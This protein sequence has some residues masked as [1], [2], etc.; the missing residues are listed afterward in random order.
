MTTRPNTQ[1]GYTCPKCSAVIHANNGGFQRHV[2]TCGV[3]WREYFWAKVDKNA[4]NGCWVWTASRKEKGYGQFLL[5]RK[6]HRAHRL[7]WKLL[8]GDPG[9][10]EVAHTCDNRLCVNPDHLF[11]ATHAENMADCKAKGRH[12]FGERGRAK[13]KEADVLEIRRLKGKETAVQLSAK[14]GVLPAHI[15]RIWCRA[16]WRHI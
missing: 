3:D 1:E 16:F 10:K 15:S 12:A 11:L 5:K 13:L 7:A 2:K 9:D 6:M 14:F 4:P 8:R